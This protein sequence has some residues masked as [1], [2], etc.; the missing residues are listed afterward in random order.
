MAPPDIDWS[1]ILVDELNQAYQRTCAASDQRDLDPDLAGRGEDFWA[2]YGSMKDEI[3]RGIELVRDH[4]PGAGETD[5][6][7]F[8]RIRK[9]C[10]ENY[11]DQA[12]QALDR[13]RRRTLVARYRT[14]DL[15]EVIRTAMRHVAC[16]LHDAAID[17]LT[18]AAVLTGIARDAACRGA[19]R[20]AVLRLTQLYPTRAAKHEALLPSPKATLAARVEAHCAEPPA[21]IPQSA[22]A[23]LLALLQKRS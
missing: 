13:A 8:D 22:I 11:A 3:R 21:P 16:E 2:E 9:L 18:D 23:R 19:Q 17:S 20:H 10:A 12:T 6:A 5:L 1:S 4:P 14:A 15:Q 7:W